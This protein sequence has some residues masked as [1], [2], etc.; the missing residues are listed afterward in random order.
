MNPGSQGN[1]DGPTGRGRGRATSRSKPVE[2][3]VRDCSPASSTSSELSVETGS[4]ESDSSSCHSSPQLGGGHGVRLGRGHGSGI[5][6]PVTVPGTVKGR[7]RGKSMKKMSL[8]C[9]SSDVTSESETELSVS[10]LGPC[11]PSLPAREH[12]NILRPPQQRTLGY[13]P[14]PPTSGRPCSLATNNFKMEVKVPEGVLYMYDVTIIPPWSRL[15]RRSDKVLYQETIRRWKEVCPAVSSERHCW[16]FDGYKQLYSTRRHQNSEFSSTRLNVWC[17]EE[18]KNV[19]MVVSEVTHVLDIKI[20]Q[21]L[22]DWSCKGR[23]GGIPQESIEA[24]NVILKQATVTDLGWTSIGR[25]FFPSSGQTIDLGFGKEAWVGLFSSVRPLGWKDHGMLLSLNVDT[26]NKPAVKNLHLTE[27][28]YIQE[29]LP[30]RKYGP[31]DLAAGLN[32]RQTNALGKDLQQLK[33]KYEVPDKNGVR[34]RQYKINDVRKLSASKE[35]ISVDGE[36]ISIVKYFKKQYDLDLKY[37]NLPCL[38]VGARDKTT[39]IPMEFCTLVSQPMPR[40]KKLQDDAIATMIRQTAIKPLDRQKKILDGLQANNKM[41]KEDPYAKEFGISVAGSMTKLTGRILNPP[42]IEYKDNGKKQNVIEI[43][44]N[45]PGKWFMEKNLFVD[46]VK[47]NNWALMDLAGF[48]DKEINEV[49]AGFVSVGKENGIVFSNG[50]GHVKASM[51]DAEEAMDKIETYLE[52][53]KQSFEAKGKKLELILIVFPFKAGFLY[54]KI[55]QLGDNLLNLTTQCCLK[56]NLYKKGALNK[57]VIANICLKINSKLGGINHVLSRSC[58]PKILKRPVMIMG[59]DVSHPAPEARGVKP[60]IA[61]IVASVDPKAVKY[62]VK[63]R[64]QDRGLDNNEEVI[65]DMKSVTKDLLLKFFQ[66]NNGKKPEKLVMFR[67][68][69]SEGQVSS[70]ILVLFMLTYTLLF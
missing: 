54:D 51:R 43:N 68:G 60:S 42:S 22:L 10:Q 1:D 17:A 40:K 47:V 8:T 16:V 63:V 9:S 65:K 56:T 24:L 64:V 39:Y 67:D 14:G 49:K 5:D 25:C 37:P 21:D 2:V 48:T 28:D 15:Y 55:K 20:T 27:S 12:D 33:V 34:K 29:V 61:A 66:E 23:S 53:L 13:F 44:K 59:A 31:V 36:V 4:E 32:T 70:Y 50:P 41:Y 6:P 3:R 69:V 30:Q 58:R 57:Q 38:W 35:V 46:G 18:E 45:N 11:L 19:E 62:E 7:G 26:S 52:N